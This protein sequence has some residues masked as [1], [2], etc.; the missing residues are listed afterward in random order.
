MA[1]SRPLLEPVVR[2]ENPWQTLKTIAEQIPDSRIECKQLDKKYTIKL[3]RPNHM[4]SSTEMDFTVAGDARMQC[5]K[6]AFLLDCFD[7]HRNDKLNMP[8]NTRPGLPHCLSNSEENRRFWVAAVMHFIALEQ[9]PRD[10]RSN[11]GGNS[12]FLTGHSMRTP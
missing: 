2:L 1:L 5:L 11:F 10:G 7:F 3:S 4:S 8:R 12:S 6:I 9:K